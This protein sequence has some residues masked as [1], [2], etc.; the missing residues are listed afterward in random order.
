MKK[1]LI[2]DDDYE[3]QANLSEILRGAGYYTDAAT[4]GKEALDKVIRE[5]FDIALL[6]LMMPGMT[7]M[8]T[9]R[10]IKRVNPKMRV[11]M[12]TAF[13]TVEN[14]VDAIK[15]G[16]SDYMSKPFKIEQLLAAIRRVFEEIRFEDGIR[17]LALDNALSSLSNPIRRRVMKSL[18]VMPNMHF[19]EI[20]KDLGIDDHTKVIFHL[21]LLKECGIIGQDDDRSYYLTGEGK[22]LLDCLKILENYISTDTALT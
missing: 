21:R 14:A 3:L 18:S 9:I 16:V 1:I 11:I 15:G 5:R 2:V 12:I 13:A 17:C 4:S 10:E 7:G 6:D 19:M 8:D 22:R 20:V